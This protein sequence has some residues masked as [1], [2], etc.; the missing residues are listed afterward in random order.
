MIEQTNQVATP[1]EQLEALTNSQISDAQ[2]LQ[3][4]T[5]NFLKNNVVSPSELARREKAT[6]CFSFVPESELIAGHSS[7]HD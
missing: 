6:G 7:R 3:Q 2:A 5:S 1:L 4:S